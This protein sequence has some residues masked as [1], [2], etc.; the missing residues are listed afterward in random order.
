M[1]LNVEINKQKTQT[2]G[3]VTFFLHDNIKRWQ[4]L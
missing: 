2:Y 1:N 3:N 4:P